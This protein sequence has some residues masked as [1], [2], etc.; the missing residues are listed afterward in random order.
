MDKVIETVT[1][2]L[3]NDPEQAAKCII[4]MCILIAVN[5]VLTFIGVAIVESK[6]NNVVR[7]LRRRGINVW[8]S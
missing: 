5:F 4:M 7:Q 8:W 1:D 6:V 2:W 3:I